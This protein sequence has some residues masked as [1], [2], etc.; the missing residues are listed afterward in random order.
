[1]DTIVGWTT[2]GNRALDLAIRCV[3]VGQALTLELLIAA[4]VEVTE[5]DA[6]VPQLAGVLPALR[7]QRGRA[8]DTVPRNA[9]VAFVLDDL[10]PS[11]RH[12][13]CVDPDRRSVSAAGL[14]F[15]LVFARDASAAVPEGFAY[16]ASRGFERGGFDVIF[17]AVEQRIEASARRSLEG[18]WL[19]W[20][21]TGGLTGHGSSEPPDGASVLELHV[22]GSAQARNG[23][24]LDT[25]F[26][27][28]LE[29]NRSFSDFFA[30][31][32]SVSQISLSGILELKDSQHFRVRYP[33]Y[34]AFVHE[35]I[36][37]V[38]ETRLLTQV[39]RSRDKRRR[40]V[41]L[42]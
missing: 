20:M 25:D 14:L 12:R 8:T 18:V 2:E 26:A 35:Y 27:V 30:P 15:A 32:F 42:L 21:T 22:D 39:I 17:R 37:D 11:G 4:L 5:I 23:E 24:T 9:A 36:K 6:D 41:T 33:A 13:F 3:P 19:W 38:P 16:L 7:V 29:L 31:I 28:R 40:K 1:M 34:D 10:A